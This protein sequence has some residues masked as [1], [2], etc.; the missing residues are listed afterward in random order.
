MVVNQMV[1]QRS[2]IRFLM[3]EKCKPCEIYKTC[4]VYEKAC[5][6]QKTNRQNM[7]LPLLARVENTVHGMETDWLSGREKVSATVISKEGHTDSL[8]EHE[9]THNYWF[10]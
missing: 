3:A 4:D 10:P 8:L 9:K 2:A 5:F 1:L 7:G 6:S